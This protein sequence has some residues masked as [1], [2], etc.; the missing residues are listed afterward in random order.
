MAGQCEV[1]PEPTPRQGKCGGDR[2]KQDNDR[3]DLVDEAPRKERAEFRL[4]FP[5]EEVLIDGASRRGSRAICGG[6]AAAGRSAAQVGLW[7]G[8]L[9]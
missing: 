9:A 5:L 7:Q 6:S 3:G 2:G 8:W 4:Q 1:F